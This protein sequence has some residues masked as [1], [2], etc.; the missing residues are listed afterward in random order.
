M[1][2]EEGFGVVV[3]GNTGGLNGRGTPAPLADAPPGADGAAGGPVRDDVAPHPEV[4]PAPCGWYARDAGPITNL[5][6]RLAMGAGVEV[7]VR[8]RELVLTPLTPVPGMRTPLVLHPD[9]PRVYRIT[10][11]QYGWNLRIEFTEDRPPRL[12]LDLMSFE[13]QPAW[14]SPRPW[15]TA[16]AAAAV[17]RSRGGTSEATG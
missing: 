12:L 15:A 9:D 16:S 13:K 17:R 7:R 8:H 3:L 5:F 4:W 14:Q 1:T 6:P 2:P 10:L 11:P